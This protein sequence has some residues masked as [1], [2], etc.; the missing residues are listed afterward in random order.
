MMEVHMKKVYKILLAILGIF[1]L[2]IIIDLIAI[3]TFNRPLFV[4]STDN[5]GEMNKVYRGLLY[6]TYNCAEL[7]M[8]QIKFKGVKYSCSNLAIKNNLKIS[9]AKNKEITKA[10][11]ITDKN[12]DNY[13]IYYYGIDSAEIQIDDKNY[14]FANAVSLNL[15][16][17]NEFMNDISVSTVYRDGGTKR[18]EGDDFSIIK[19]N[20]LD[21]NSDVYLGNRDMSY[22]K[23]FC[24]ERNLEKYGTFIRTYNVL[25]IADSNDEKYLY[26]ALRMYMNEEVETVRVLR[27]FAKNIKENNNYEF[28]FN[29]LDNNVEDNIES[30][31]KN[32]KLISIVKTDKV[33]M[34]QIQTNLR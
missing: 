11:L 34:D 22:E 5:Y 21:G 25:N 14:D 33:G 12:E 1:F 17:I 30:I 9:E 2:S 4:I 8:S 18:W 29:Y 27:S 13:I 31:F 32:A 3:L 7:P 20:T 26:L 28:T 19:C 16:D 15:F 23:D 24:K 10:T 6:D